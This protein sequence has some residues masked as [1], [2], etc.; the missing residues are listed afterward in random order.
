[1]NPKT[2]QIRLSQL[3][4]S[5][6]Q[7]SYIFYLH[8][9]SAEEALAWVAR[10]FEGIDTRQTPANLRRP[11]GHSD[12]VNVTDC[13]RYRK[14]ARI[15]G[16]FQVVET[17]EGHF[18]QPEAEV[19]SNLHKVF[20]NLKSERQRLAESFAG[21]KACYER[22]GTEWIYE[23]LVLIQ[24]MH[25]K[26]LLWEESLW[27]EYLKVA[28]KANLV[29]PEKKLPAILKHIVLSARERAATAS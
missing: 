17:P 8:V 27:Q 13:D 3:L 16:R 12:P 4:G 7:A 24:Q 15:Q 9:D 10:V 23:R 6:T 14:R 11:I 2:F 22:D 18:R 21:L 1:M 19:A 20:K 26:A 28:P 29:L 25:A 5:L